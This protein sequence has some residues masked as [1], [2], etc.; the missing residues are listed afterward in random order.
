M[1]VL[2]TCPPM[3]GQLDKLQEILKENDIKIVVHE[4][5]AVM[6]EDELCKIIG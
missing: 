1:K 3:I 4:F 5:T 2:L 6:G